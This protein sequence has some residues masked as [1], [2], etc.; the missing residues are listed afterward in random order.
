MN[1]EPIITE[2]GIIERSKASICFYSLKHEWNALIINGHFNLNPITE[3]QE[4]NFTGVI[5]FTLFFNDPIYFKSY[6]F[7]FYH[8]LAKLKSSFDLV[9]SS[10]LIK[11]I[12]GN[13]KSRFKH[14]VFV[15]NDYVY[16]IISDY[17]ILELNCKDDNLEKYFN[18]NNWNVFSDKYKNNHSNNAKEITLKF[19]VDERLGTVIDGIIGENAIEWINKKL[20]EL[21]NIS[22]IECRKFARLKN[23]LK[24]MLMRM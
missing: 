24:E 9:N 21:N 6:D 17:Y 10:K 2:V 23:R 22:P 15:T 3:K 18:E 11:E 5:K 19:S 7:D 12:T 4:D 8:N 13:K 1:T 16:E 20:P 14:Y